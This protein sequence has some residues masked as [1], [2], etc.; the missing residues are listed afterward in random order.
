MK[1]PKQHLDAFL[2]K[3]T[4]EDNSSFVEI[5]EEHEKKHREKHAWLFENEDSRKEVGLADHNT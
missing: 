4:S 1:E 3:N 2:S 5:L